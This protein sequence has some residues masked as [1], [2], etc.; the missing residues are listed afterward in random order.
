MLAI[1]SALHVKEQWVI[2]VMREM[3]QEE[4]INIQANSA[5]Y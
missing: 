2:R 3:A 4:G 1:I 5:I